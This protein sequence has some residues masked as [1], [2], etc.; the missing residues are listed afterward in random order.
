MAGLVTILN[1]TSKCARKLISSSSQSMK[2]FIRSAM[3][4][5]PFVGPWPLL[6]FHKLFFCFT[7]TIGLLGR[8]I[9]PSQGRY[10]H[11]GQQKHR[12]KAHSDIH[13]FSGIRTHDPSIRVSEDSSCLDRA[14]TV[15]GVYET[16]ACRNY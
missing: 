12:I 2:Y 7:Q 5:P 6:Q 13:A 8:E 4:V 11:T 15:V 1:T 14:A 10:L 16:N 3:A 9:R